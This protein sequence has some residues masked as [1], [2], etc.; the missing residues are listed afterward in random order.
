MDLRYYF[1]L[2]IFISYCWNAYDE[3]QKQFIKNDNYEKEKIY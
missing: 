3:S 1:E 2:N